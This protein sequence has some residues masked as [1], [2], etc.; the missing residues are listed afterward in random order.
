[1]PDVD[2]WD[3]P[4]RIT[5]R[6]SPGLL[7]RL[8]GVLA[9]GCTPFSV[10]A[11]APTDELHRA[12]RQ[13][14]AKHA[15]E[16]QQLAA[17]CEQRGLTEEAKRTREV[18]GPRD[19]YKMYLTVLPKQAGGPKLPAGASADVIEWDRQLGQLRRDQAA[20][21]FELAKRAIRGR[22][23]SLAYRLVLAASRANPDHK[24]VRRILGY[25]KHGEKWLT[26]FE[27]RQLRAGKVWHEKFGWLAKS[28]VHRY[29]QGQRFTG[30][31]WVAA[32]Q[33]AAL[34]ADISAAW[35]VRTE[36]YEIHTNHS[37]E[38]GA[39]LGVKLERLFRYWQQLFVRYHASEADVAALFDGRA[40]SRPPMRRF[41]V[42]LFRDREDYNRS[43]R[44]AMPGII[45]S[46]G[47][48]YQQ[49]R[50]AYFFLGKDYEDRTLYH[51]ATH[52]LFHQSRPVAPF[53][54]KDAN[55]WI[56][57]GIA[58]SME[59]LR[60]EGGYYVLGGFDDERLYAALYRL[61]H[62]NFYVPLEELTTYGMEKLQTD[63]RVA[64]LY[65][66]SAGLTHFLIFY[67]DGRYR[68][69]LVAYLISVYAG[70]DTPGTLA[71]LTAT[72]YDELDKQ[73]RRFM[74]EGKRHQESS[75]GQR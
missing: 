67:D 32:A 1:M 15:A 12:A 49:T 16:L 60:P 73:Y 66:Q 14:K 24:E 37:L 29:E 17:W 43:L 46:V 18:Y 50:T 23:A 33:D 27:A 36:H 65:S 62:D 31:R 7:I 71:R 25:Q 70:R 39:Q 69:A 64:T 56:V 21:L 42:V 10:Y 72:N 6:R 8:A 38:A 34:H 75:S 52:Q 40:R 35:I 9:V 59:T 11:L 4:V 26:S 2:P 54:G 20:A 53:V 30:R 74:E 68:D 3:P 41:R 47:L 63:K 55:F 22:R 5:K 28:Y 45:K 57:E 13:F 51:E 48:Y 19:P 58:M 44:A 61:L